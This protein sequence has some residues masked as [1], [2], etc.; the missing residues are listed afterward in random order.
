ML[1]EGKALIDVLTLKLDRL[2]LRKEEP[3]QSALF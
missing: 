3:L 2:K 1:F